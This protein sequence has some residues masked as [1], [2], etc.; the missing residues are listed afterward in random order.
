MADEQTTA[1][2]AA[3]RPGRAPLILS[4]AGAG[5]LVLGVLLY[6]ASPGPSVTFGWFAYTPLSDVMFS[7]GGVL[8]STLGLI[9]LVLGV[10]GLL[11]L[12]FSAGW[13]L[14]VRRSR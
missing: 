3:G 2:Q 1:V 12:A 6:F 4:A 10:L 8:I 14:G 5:T 13:L 9:G 7:P 11:A